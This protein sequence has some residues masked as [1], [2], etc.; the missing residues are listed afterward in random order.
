M[1]KQRKHVTSSSKSSTSPHSVVS[2]GADGIG[3]WRQQL[4][5]SKFRWSIW[6]K[7]PSLI[8]FP[9]SIK[10][11]PKPED[12]K[13]VVPHLHSHFSR[14]STSSFSSFLWGPR[15]VHGGFSPTSW[16]I[17]ILCSL[18]DGRIQ[19]WNLQ[20]G[21]RRRRSVTWGRFQPP[22]C[23]LNI[24][25][26]L[27]SWPCG[28]L[29]CWIQFDAKCCS[30]LSNSFFCDW[31]RFSDSLAVESKIK[32]GG[33]KCEYPKVNGEWFAAKTCQNLLGQDCLCFD[34]QLALR[35]FG[36]LSV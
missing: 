10:R 9:V 36:F 15:L 22:K 35:H 34:P 30:L 8:S 27:T 32:G 17:A 19:P 6:A 3:A 12:F 13:Q 24:T 31:L 23:G 16:V 25:G 26:R 20:V 14:L 2:S 18:W 21:I 33:S 7:P 4:G 11:I 29:K 5:H 28:N 1:W